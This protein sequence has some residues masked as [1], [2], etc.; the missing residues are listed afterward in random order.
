MVK[1]DGGIH[2]FG[3]DDDCFYVGKEKVMVVSW[4]WC[5]A[6][7]LG[8]IMQWELLFLVL[9]VR[10]VSDFFCACGLGGSGLFAWLVLFLF[11]GRWYGFWYVWCKR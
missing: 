2:V 3:I 11:L 1:E 6:M 8:W 7:V 4:S 9:G 5:E 10:W